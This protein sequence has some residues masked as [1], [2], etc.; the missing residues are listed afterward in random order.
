MD[1]RAQL[2]DFEGWCNEAYPD[3][4]TGGDPWTIGV[5]CA[6]PGIHKGLIWSDDQINAQ[7]DAD[8]AEKTRQ[9]KES[10]PWFDGLNEP[11]KAVVVGMCFQ[12]GLNGMLGFKRTLAS[13]R[14]ERWAD[15]ANGMMNS[16]W[17][18]QTPKRVRRL[19]MQCETGEW[20]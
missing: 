17:A 15:A 10:L 19:A 6:K 8:I 20:Q 1:L 11:R 16:K 14:D 12:L 5:G 9:C 13:M 7:L 18:K 3:P 4:L 2:I